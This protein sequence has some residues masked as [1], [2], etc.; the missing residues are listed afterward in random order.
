MTTWKATPAKADS[1]QA[2]FDREDQLLKQLADAQFEKPTPPRE[3][4]PAAVPQTVD[5]LAVHA[6]DPDQQAIHAALQAGTIPTFADEPGRTPQPAL[7][8]LDVNAE[9]EAYAAFLAFLE[10]HKDP[11]TIVTSIDPDAFAKGLI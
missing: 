6:V 5:A 1:D 4:T 8:P 2:L 10:A 7:Q 3:P 11:A 9:R